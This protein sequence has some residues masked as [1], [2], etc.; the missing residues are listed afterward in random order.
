MNEESSLDQS[1]EPGQP[2]TEL[3]ALLK[4]MQMQL[5]HLEKKV[6]LLISRSE[7]K[8]PQ[9]RGFR[10][11]PYTKSFHSFDR[12]QHH[13][14]GDRERNPRERESTPGHFY[15]RRPQEKS[16]GVNP[17]KKSFTFKRK[18]RE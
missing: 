6:D 15:E 14:R 13:G 7:E 16:R 3:V 11:K 17:R 4:K 1:E 9:D 10:K 5:Q 2:D 18:D 12:P 8:P